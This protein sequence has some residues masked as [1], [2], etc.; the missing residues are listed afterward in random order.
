MVDHESLRSNGKDFGGLGTLQER[1]TR[2]R[3][4][5][6]KTITFTPYTLH[7]TRKPMVM[8]PVRRT[9]TGSGMQRTE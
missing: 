4:G 1:I 7:P 3:G 6:G 9:R 2:W 8:T 5:N